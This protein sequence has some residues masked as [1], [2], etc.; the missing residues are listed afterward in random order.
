MCGFVAILQGTPTI[1][2][3]SARR[4]LDT[5]ASRGPDAAGEWIEEAVFLGHR[6][7]AIIDL[8]SG[9]QPMQSADGRYV[10]VFNGEIYNFH[11]L[12]KTLLRNGAV[13]RTRSDTEVIL[14]G[15]RCWGS[16]VVDRLHGMFAFVIWDRVQSVAFAA[17]DRLGIKP[18]CWGLHR[19]TLV[20]ASTLEPFSV[21]G[22]FS[23]CDL[24]AVRDLMAFDYIPAPRTILDGVA[25]LEPGSY[26]QWHLGAHAPTV[27]RY[28]RPPMVDAALTGPDEEELEMLLAQAVKR[29]LVSDVPVG[30]FLSGGIDSSLLVALMARQSSNPIR[31]FSVAFAENEVDESPIAARVAQEFGTEHTVLRA[32]EMNADA[33]LDLL[34]RLDEPFC[35]PALVPL[36]ALSV[37][38]KQNVKVVLSGDGGDEVFGGYPKYLVGTENRPAHPLAPLL[39]RFLEMFKWRPRG[40]GRFYGRTLSSS[41][42]V[43]YDWVGYGN[44]PV[45][46][47]DLRQLIT[48]AYLD[49]VDVDNY[50]SPWERRAKRYGQHFDTDVLMRT[51]LE[52]YL[53]ENCLVKTDRAS[54]LASLEVRVPYL[55]ET[56]LERILPLPATKKINGNRLKALLLPLARR[57]LPREVW[58]RPKHGFDVPLDTRLGGAWRPALEAVLDWGESHVDLFN[59]R[60]LRRLH[61]VN[62][63]GGGID[64]DLWNP[65]VFLA[66]AMTHTVRFGCMLLFS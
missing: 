61:A 36:Y 2:H 45:F 41:D 32:E 27:K 16:Q 4:A 57:L 33:L 5:I 34:G 20:L 18:L 9:D 6:R 10:I 28:W 25:K 48:P 8:V 60:Y 24:I 12:R 46:R 42:R 37:L 3:H 65:F 15:Y 54:M 21:L 17:R 19:G 38:T 59:Y 55:D 39:H 64:R 40:M 26:L 56:I 14:E 52:T 50:F 1:S 44:F 49:A 66:W 35:D 11:E 31:T 13:F 51:D 47:K 22:P 43:R 58:A 30:A 29:Q 53:S 23:R 7:L 63:A 62:L